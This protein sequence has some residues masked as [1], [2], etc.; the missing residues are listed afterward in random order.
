[1]R[2]ENRACNWSRNKAS[3]PW[4]SL[5]DAFAVLCGM[6]RSAL[7]SLLPVAQRNH[8]ARS[9]FR[10]Y[11]ASGGGGIAPRQMERLRKLEQ[12]AN[13]APSDAYRQ[14]A[15][16]RELNRSHPELVASRI[17]SGRFASNSGVA[18]EL[19]KAQA[20]LQQGG[21]SFGA[22]AAAQQQYYGAQQYA[23]AQYGQYGGG[24]GQ[25]AAHSGAPSGGGAGGGPMTGAFS[26]MGAMGGPEAAAAAM[27]QAGAHQGATPAAPL[28][29]SAVEAS[30]K[31]QM[32]RTVR[33]RRLL[34]CV[35]LLCLLTACPPEYFH[36]HS[37]LTRGL[38]CLSATLLR[39]AVSAGLC[40]WGRHGRSRYRQQRGGRARWRGRATAR[41]E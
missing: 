10:R 33:R 29:V 23:A 22:G 25:H 4:W 41:N 3:F 8:I 7:S 11:L 38:F 40:T 16:Y 20:A 2:P 9:A 17:A 36:A 5:S 32:W 21:G 27:H 30:F 18:N 15:F 31:T 39:G 1:M 28:Y 12:E 14:L 35:L 19:A 26:G 37:T 13:A 34:A 6:L 24:A